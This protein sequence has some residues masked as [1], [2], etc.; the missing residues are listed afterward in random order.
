MLNKTVICLVWKLSGRIE[1]FTTLSKL[2]K[3]YNTDTIGVSIHTL[4]RKNLF[5]GWE[6]DMVKVIKIKVNK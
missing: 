5:N 2:Y 1:I 4:I 3:Y 6:N